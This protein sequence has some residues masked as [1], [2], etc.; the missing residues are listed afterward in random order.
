MDKRGREAEKRY[1]PTN[2]EYKTISLTLDSKLINF[3][4]T[5][6]LETEDNNMSKFIEDNLENCSFHEMPK[7]RKSGTFPIKKTF[8]FTKKFVEMIKK[9][10]NMSL[11]VE[12]RLIEKFDLK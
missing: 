8:T 5:E 2:E 4:E 6:I 10:G 12:E 7:R 1:R 11:F 9:S 3:I